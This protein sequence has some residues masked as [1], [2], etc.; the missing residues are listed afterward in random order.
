MRIRPGLEHEF[1]EVMA[2]YRNV[3]DLQGMDIARLVEMFCEEFDHLRE[4]EEPDFGEAWKMFLEE[5]KNH[6]NAMPMVGLI[7]Y[8]V[9]TYWEMGPLLGAQLPTLE[10]IVLRDTIQD[11][12]DEIDRRSAESGNDPTPE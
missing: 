12:A 9:I 3:G 5:H 1:L 8:N 7:L 11:I 6:V 2:S 4:E 10:R